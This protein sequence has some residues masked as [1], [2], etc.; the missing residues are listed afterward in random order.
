MLEQIGRLVCVF[1]GG[2]MEGAGGLCVD[3]RVGKRGRGAQGKVMPVKACRQSCLDWNRV[4]Q[5]RDEETSSVST[6]A[7]L[8]QQR[9]G[10]SELMMLAQCRYPMLVPVATAAPPAKPPRPAGLA[11]PDTAGWGN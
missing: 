7:A 4:C 9:V 8:N 10:F 11:K 1:E 6:C 5:G 3:E 2:R